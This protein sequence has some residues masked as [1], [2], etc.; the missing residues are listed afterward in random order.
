M[1]ALRPLRRGGQAKTS[2]SVATTLAA[3][4]VP[5]DVWIEVPGGFVFALCGGWPSSQT[6]PLRCDHPPGASSEPPQPQASGGYEVRPS[7]PQPLVF[8]GGSSL[9][10]GEKRCAQGF[11]PGPSRIKPAEFLVPPNRAHP[12][13]FRSWICLVGYLP[14]SQGRSFGLC[15]RHRT[16]VGGPPRGAGPSDGAP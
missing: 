11:A 9:I 4:I 13:A 12:R 1:C 2:E 8:G 7:S 14:R 15:E 5:C 10:R 16:C 6:P 3:Q